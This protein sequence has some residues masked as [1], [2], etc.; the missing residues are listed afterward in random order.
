MNTK[1]ILLSILFIS[2][3]FLSCK[4]NELGGK[5]TIKGKVAHH[6]KAIANAMVFIKF[7]AKEFPG[8]DTALYDAKVRADAS[9]NYSF[10]VYKGDY[11]L[12]GYGYD[13]SILSPFLVVGGAPVHL[14]NHEDL[15][16]DVAVTED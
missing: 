12:Y 10:K 6:S 3:F 13:Y 16:V 5:S 4:K 15:D 11:Y 14:R 1:A 2:V 7:R 8:S 9:G